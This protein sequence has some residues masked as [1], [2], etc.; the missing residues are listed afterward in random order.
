MLASLALIAL[1]QVPD[2]GPAYDGLRHQLHVAIPRVDTTITVDGVLDEPVW[3]RAARLVGFSE[4]QPVDSRPAEEPTEV[5]V[6]YSPTAIYFGIR[7]REIH[8]DVVHATHADRD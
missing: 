5:L 2:S 1:L 3:R 8:G 7:A 6:W 4:Y